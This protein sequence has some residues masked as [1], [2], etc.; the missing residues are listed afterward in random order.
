ME[1]YKSNVKQFKLIQNSKN[2]FNFLGLF[3]LA[4]FVIFLILFI[5]EKGFES[6]LFRINFDTLKTIFISSLALGI[7]TFILQAISQNK[8]ADSSILGIGSVNL[9]FL[10]LM[11]SKLDLGNNQSISTY[12][13]LLPIV[14]ISVSC[15]ASIIIFL[16]SKKD[17]YKFNKKFILAGILL[18]LVFTSFALSISSLMTSAKQQIIS[19]YANG[20]FEPANENHFYVAITFLIICIIWMLIILRKFKI[21]TCNINIA[22]QLGVNIKSIYFQ[23]IIIVG[24]LTGIAFLLS[25]NII[26]LGLLGGNIAYAIFKKDYKYT[27]IGSGVSAFIIAGITFFINRNILTNTNLNTSYLIPLIS[28]PYF[29][30]LILKK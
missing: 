29:L 2:L 18:N 13:I 17:Q 26:F 16:L 1:L 12:N 8:L 21:V 23:S 25:G 3:I 28:T 5:S 14:F 30:F 19:S 15:F 10:V 9:L 27:L 7:S 24:I 22:S 11:V 20:N 4:F 6:I